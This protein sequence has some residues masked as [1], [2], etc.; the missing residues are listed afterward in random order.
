M[1]I[2]VISRDGQPEYA[3]VPWEQYQALLKAAG[4]LESTVVEDAHATSQET[5]SLPCFSELG[6]LREGKGLAAEQLARSVGISPVYLALIESG[7]RHPDAA[8]RR[9]LAWELGVP[10]WSEPT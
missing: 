7:E 5:S 2:Q 10:G 1:G 8:I 3:V 6:R 9:S 4:Q